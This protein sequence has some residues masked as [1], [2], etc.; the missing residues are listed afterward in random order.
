MTFINTKMNRVS[1]GLLPR[2]LEHWHWM[3]IQEITPLVFAA[4]LFYDVPLGLLHENRN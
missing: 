4:H 1:R 3:E 2:F